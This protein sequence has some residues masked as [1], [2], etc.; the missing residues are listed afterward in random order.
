M[1]K[2]S[3]AMKRAENSS[4]IVPSAGEISERKIGATNHPATGTAAEAT[5]AAAA[6][7]I[8]ARAARVRRG[9]SRRNSRAERMA[10]PVVIA[11]PDPAIHQA[12]EGWMPGSS[13]GMMNAADAM[14]P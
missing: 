6:L 1:G 14:L 2:G 7:S 4:A 12:K 10:F 8:A 9:R 11:G 5:R 3:A 13:P